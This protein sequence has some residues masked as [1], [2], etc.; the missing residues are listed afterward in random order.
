MSLLNE[1]KNLRKEFPNDQDFGSAVNRLI[2]AS[3]TCC[4]EKENR[5]TEMKFDTYPYGWNVEEVKCK[6][7]GKI[8]EANIDKS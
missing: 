5:I 6:V 8:I 1:I 3:K 2:I 4:D 7:C